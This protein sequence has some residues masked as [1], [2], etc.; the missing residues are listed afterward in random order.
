MHRRQFL[1]LLCCSGGAGSIAGCVNLPSDEPHARIDVI[2]LQNR[3]DEPVELTL[4]ITDG[5]IP[6]FTETVSLPERTNTAF[7]TPVAEPGKY[8]ISVS[9][10]D[11]RS[12]VDTTEHIS[13][14]EPYVFV[15]FR[16]YRG[17]GVAADDIR[18]YDEE[19]TLSDE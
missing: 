5:E 4:K 1:A 14:D 19:Q 15:I 2:S 3:S 10:E 11:G 16:V 12:Q 9:S 8:S 17:G 6:V 13:T 18:T 7:E